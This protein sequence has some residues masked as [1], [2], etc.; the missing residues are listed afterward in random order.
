M[1]TKKSKNIKNKSYFNMHDASKCN[2]YIIYN[3]LLY[4]THFFYDI[5]KTETF[6]YIYNRKTQ[7]LVYTIES[8]V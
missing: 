3:F 4:K 5:P 6:P 7:L 8:R 1:E 2:N